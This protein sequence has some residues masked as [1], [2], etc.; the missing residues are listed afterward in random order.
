M[1]IRW[2]YSTRV[3]EVLNKHCLVCSFWVRAGLGNTESRA[4]GVVRAPPAVLQTA[5]K[6]LRAS[7]QS[8]AWVEGAGDD[9]DWCRT[10]KW[11]CVHPDSTDIL[12][13]V[14]LKQLVNSLDDG[15]QGGAGWGLHPQP[16]VLPL[17][18]Q[19]FPAYGLSSYQVEVGY[20]DDKLLNQ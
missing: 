2:K 11:V 8:R 10:T 12:P 13:S 15:R 6:F 7:T 5:Q 20:I 18:P 19:Q 9:N 14:V 3:Y 17:P 4:K 16:P 1:R